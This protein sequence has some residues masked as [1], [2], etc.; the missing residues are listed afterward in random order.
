MREDLKKIKEILESVKG[1]ILGPV[2]LVGNIKL[3]F[4]NWN[5]KYH[6]FKGERSSKLSQVVKYEFTT[7]EARVEKVIEIIN[8]QKNENTV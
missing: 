3:G 5:N 8:E 1:V 2:V 7:P 6:L 4:G